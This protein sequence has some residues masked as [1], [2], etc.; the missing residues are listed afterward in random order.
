M[1][2]AAR[3]QLKVQFKAWKDTLVKMIKRKS[4]IE[5]KKDGSF[6][7]VLPPDLIRLVW[8]TTLQERAAIEAANGSADPMASA[9]QT[10]SA[11]LT[12]NAQ[13]LLQAK[14]SSPDDEEQK[15]TKALQK[16]RETLVAERS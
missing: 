13:E 9:M 7:F 2:K 11:E 3:R 5:I 8:A 12:K 6:C 4:Q 15:A 10:I 1:P 14:E 16:M